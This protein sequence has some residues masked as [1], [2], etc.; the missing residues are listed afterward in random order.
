M[1]YLKGS[2]DSSLTHII[3]CDGM[4][5]TWTTTSFS[6]TC[7]CRWAEM[8]NTNSERGKKW[9]LVCSNFI[10]CHLQTA[11]G[12]PL[13]SV[14]FSLL[15]PN[16]FRLCISYSSTSKLFRYFR[17]IGRAFQAAWLTR[18]QK[19]LRHFISASLHSNRWPVD[20]L[21]ICL[22]SSKTEVIFFL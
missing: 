11:V 12:D 17:W 14:D 19:W 4:I 18:N 2:S 1:R 21:F 6:L 9:R 22:L 13:L 20:T 5:C 10:V 3:K 16:A 15:V 7:C 8:H